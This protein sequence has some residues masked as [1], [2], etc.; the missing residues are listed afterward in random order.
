MFV[1][2]ARYCGASRSLP[3]SAWAQWARSRAFA[4]KPPA[5]PAAVTTDVNGTSD[6]PS[7]RS[8]ARAAL[9]VDA[10]R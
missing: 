7:D 3:Y 5:P 4:A 10:K 1:I 9:A 6:V 8:I 2:A